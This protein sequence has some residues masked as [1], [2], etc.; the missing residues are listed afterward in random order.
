MNVSY[1]PPLLNTFSG[2]K[3]D[4]TD[5]NDIDCALRESFEEIGLP[6]S[7]GD[8]H[9]RAEGSGVRVITTGKSSISKHGLEVIPIIAQIPVPDFIAKREKSNS[10][11]LSPMSPSLPVDDTF[12]PLLNSSEVSVLFTLPLHHFLESGPGYK[13]RDIDWMGTR[14]RMHE[15]NVTLPPEEWI[16]SKDVATSSTITTTPVSSSSA[17]PPSTSASPRSFRIWGLTSYM[18]VSTAIALFQQQPQFDIRAA[19]VHKRANSPTIDN[20]DSKL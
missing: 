8:I 6:R 19:M 17:Q 14:V 13:Y 5:V 20:T 3:R 16:D 7:S 2:G 4:P 11:A 18:L 15:F 12:T 9:V 1:P 10:S